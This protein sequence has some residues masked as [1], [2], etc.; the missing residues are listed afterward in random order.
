MDYQELTKL[1]AD[2]CLDLPLRFIWPFLP[3]LETL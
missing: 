2:P 3:L 1:A